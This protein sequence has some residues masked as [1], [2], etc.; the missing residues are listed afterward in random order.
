MTRTAS[1]SRRI[2]LA[3]TTALASLALAGCATGS[4][5]RAD[6]SA[7]KAQQ[8]LEKG[9]GT[10]AVTHAEAAVLAEPRN[11]SYRAVL[12][13]AYME[14]GRFQSA[15]TSFDDALELGDTSPRTALGLALAQIAAGDS[16]GAINTLE[17]WRADLDPADV[18]LA[19][20]LAGYPER[21]VHILGNALRNGQN[22]PK[23]RQ[24]LAYAYALHGE[25]RAAR[26]MAAEDVPAD[27]LDERIGEWAQLA[28]NGN[29]QT[30]VAAL[31]AVPVVSDSGQPVALALHNNPGTEGLALEA[32]SNAAPATDLAWAPPQGELPALAAAAPPVAQPV[33]QPVEQP[34]PRPDP[35]PDN[36]A[37]A[38]TALAAPPAP[39]SAAPAQIAADA[40]RFATAPAVQDAPVARKTEPRRSARVAPAPSAKAAQAG[41]HLVQLGSFS[42]DASARRAW[43][44]YAKRYPQLTDHDMVITRAVVRGKTYFRVSA[45]GFGRDASRSMCAKVKSGGNGCIT[46]AANSPLPG[47]VDRGVRMASR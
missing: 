42:S 16:Q 9:R 17:E 40:V 18:G 46:W 36:F 37:A 33:V 34:A 7:S 14:A 38:F 8:A 3:A 47:A 44:I 41:T 43:D 13:A 12:G 20:A 11:A 24:N 21:G 5:P 27:Q 19:V 45:A 22:T 29:A 26:L 23:V 4:A 6:L 2:A 25:W 15:A 10:S 39:S 31:L 32:A 28:Q 35:A 30:R 1:K